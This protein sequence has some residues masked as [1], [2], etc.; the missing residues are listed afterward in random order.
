MDDRNGRG[1]LYVARQLCVVSSKAASEAHRHWVGLVG[2]VRVRAMRSR[3]KLEVCF[4][5]PPVLAPTP[6]PG[7]PSVC[8][9][10]DSILHR[11]TALPDRHSV[12]SFVG[13]A[14]DL[15]R[16]GPVREGFVSLSLLCFFSPHSAGGVD[17]DM[18]D[19]ERGFPSQDWD[20]S[21]IRVSVSRFYCSSYS[22]FGTLS[23]M[24][25]YIYIFAFA[26]RVDLSPS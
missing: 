12:S 24:Y 10:F 6:R 25:I 9:R 18:M 4:R 20:A 26:L 17:M 19:E 1:G 15:H 7:T 22:S 13:P 2:G 23:A 8:F 5:P 14:C 16:P 21:F 3:V 11:A